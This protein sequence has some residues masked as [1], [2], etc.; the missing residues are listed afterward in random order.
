[1]DEWPQARRGDRT[2][3]AALVGQL[4]DFLAGSGSEAGR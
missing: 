3:I 1:V 4:R 2:E